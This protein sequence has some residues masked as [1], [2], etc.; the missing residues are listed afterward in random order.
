MEK[1]YNESFRDYAQRWRTVATQVQPPLIE[2]EV[3]MIFLSTLQES[4][5]DRLMPTET[6]SFAN[7]IKV[8]NLINHSIKNDRIDIG[9]SSSK[10][11]KGNFPKKKEGEAQALYQQ[12]QSINL[13][14]IRHT[15]T[16]RTINH[17]TQFRV[18]KHLLWFPTIHLLITKHK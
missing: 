13:G 18:T 4:Y 6:G 2:T 16:T 14:G 10:P 1:K 17:I 15:R 11:K 3:I 9:E 8:G 7:M 12:N 5:Y